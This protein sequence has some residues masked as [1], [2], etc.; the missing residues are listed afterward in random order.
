MPAVPWALLPRV[1]SKDSFFKRFVRLFLIMC[2]SM[3]A[4]VGMCIWKQGPA[5]ARRGHQE[6]QLQEMGAGNA[7]QI[8]S[9]NS[10][11]F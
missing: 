8:C 6:L 7:T 5:E 9:K 10:K 4:C 11:C 1:H 3:L 2:M